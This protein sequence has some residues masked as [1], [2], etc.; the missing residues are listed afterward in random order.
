MV[1]SRR[2]FSGLDQLILDNLNHFIYI[3]NINLCQYFAEKVT[4]FLFF[5]CRRE[6][7]PEDY[8]LCTSLNEE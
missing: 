5:L 1:H 3:I 6:C 2:F 7:F 8:G 4:F